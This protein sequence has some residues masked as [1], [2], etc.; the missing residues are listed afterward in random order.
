MHS[1]IRKLN[2]S[3]RRQ[4]FPCNVSPWR[5]RTMG[6]RPCWGVYYLERELTPPIH[7]LSSKHLQSSGGIL[8]WTLSRRA[9]LRQ[10]TSSLAQ[11]EIE[12]VLYWFW[13][14]YTQ[15]VR[16]TPELAQLEH[17]LVRQPV[18]WLYWLSNELMFELSSMSRMGNLVVSFACHI[19]RAVNEGCVVDYSVCRL[20]CRQHT[21]SLL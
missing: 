14:L 21:T 12:C 1:F 20:Q 13:S 11:P 15:R 4:Y 7:V 17:R 3:R 10:F 19:V 9:C 6:W 8:A 16:L 2:H 5:P 18:H